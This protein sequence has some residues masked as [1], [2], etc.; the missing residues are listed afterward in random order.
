MCPACQRIRD[1]NPADFLTLSG[2][3]LLARNEEA[4]EKAEYPL[5]QIMDIEARE[6]IAE[7]ARQ[8]AN[9]FTESNLDAWM[10][11]YAENAV[12]TASRLPFWVEG[13]DAIRAE[14]VGPKG[15]C[16]CFPELGLSH[17]SG[18]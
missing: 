13:K 14:Y 1:H 12:Y 7:L 2:R 11:M 18:R 6:D 15:H 5:H 17:Q 9:T 3:F 16:R 10:A 4:T 8:R